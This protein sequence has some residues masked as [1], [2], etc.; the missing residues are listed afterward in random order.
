[1][2]ELHVE[3]VRVRHPGADE[4]VLTGVDLHVRDATRTVL[5]GGSGS[6]KT[7]LL[8][9]V[10]GLAP[11]TGGRVLLGGRDVTDL[12]PGARDVAMVAQHAPLQPH[13]DV[14]RNLGFALRL[15]R[16]PREEED[17]RVSAEARAFGLEDLLG[18]R[19][20]TLAAGQRHEVALARAL[21]RRGT[22]LLLDEPFARVDAQRR[23]AL[24][25]ELL[26]MQEGY[27]VT[28]LLATNDP[29]VAHA[30]AH[31]V[32]VLDGGRIVQVGAPQ[33]VVARPASITV[34]ELLVLP[35]INLLP[36]L[37]ERSGRGHR[38]VAGP[39]AVDLRR[40]LPAGDVTVGISPAHL[41]LAHGGARVPVQRRVVLGADVE[42][43]V[44][45]PGGSVVRISAGRDAPAAGSEV[46]VRAAA[47]HIHLFDPRTGLALAH[48]V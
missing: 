2:V 9:A 24:R 36:G 35:P 4:D 48:G 6:G 44:G 7:S 10:A 20:T 5:L 21:V 28:S 46:A 13:L 18:R 11:V 14:R 45:G 29:L 31:Q 27:G 37:V 25:R 3:Q 40:P 19:P 42:L 15:R 32:A 17:A 41:E 43:T 23:A 38:L 33:D 34:A 8:R 30:L 39:I 26:R 1:V 22:L 12:P 16:V 47:Q